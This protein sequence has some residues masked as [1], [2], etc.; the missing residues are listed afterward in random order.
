M[1]KLFEKIFG[2]FCKL[3]I[4]INKPVDSFGTF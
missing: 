2:G 1:I 3:K 4:K